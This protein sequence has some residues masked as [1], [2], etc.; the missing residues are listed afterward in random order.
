MEGLL[1]YNP[2]FHTHKKKKQEK[3]K[4]VETQLAE[5]VENSTKKIW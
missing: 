1:L 2:L 5:A 3:K 4:T